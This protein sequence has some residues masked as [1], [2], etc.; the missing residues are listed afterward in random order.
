MKHPQTLPQIPKKPMD[1]L[2][3]YLR[4]SKV[5]RY[6]PKGAYLLDVG[7]GDGSFLRFLDSHIQFGMGIDPLIST[8]IELDSYA[9]YPGAFPHDF[10]TE[11]R[12]DVVSLLAVV[13][14]IPEYDLQHAADICWNILKPNGRVIITVPHPFVDTIL[15][16]LKFLRIVNGLSLDEHYGFNPEY[17]P[18][19]FSRWKLIRKVRWQLG[20]NYLFIFEKTAPCQ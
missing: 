12:F 3:E 17:L 14:H 18:N 13:E 6:I 2:L 16:V 4:F 15:N 20:L 7:T 8:S 9:F 5:K 1:R 11:R 19:I 10:E